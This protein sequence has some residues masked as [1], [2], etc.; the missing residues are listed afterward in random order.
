MQDHTQ[1]NTRNAQHSTGPTSPQGLHNSSRNSRKHGLYSQIPSNCEESYEDY[2]VHANKLLAVLKPE[3][4]LQECFAK[5]MIDNLWRLEGYR[6]HET[7]ATDQ[8]YKAL[9]SRG[10]QEQRLQNCTHKA[11]KALQELQ[12][13]SARTRLAALVARSEQMETEN[14]RLREESAC[15]DSEIAGLRAAQNQAAGFVPHIPSNPASDPADSPQTPD[16]IKVK[17]AA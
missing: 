9:E 4:A 12:A 16:E 13:Q 11:H 14:A 3:D 6:I 5:I 2:V 1:R 8:D 10:R 15:K 17:R 7:H